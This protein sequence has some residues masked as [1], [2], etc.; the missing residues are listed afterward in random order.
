[1]KKINFDKKDYFSSMNFLAKMEAEKIK[2][3]MN[4]VARLGELNLQIKTLRKN[5]MELSKMAYRK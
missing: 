4:I 1:M 3:G 5:R 2:E